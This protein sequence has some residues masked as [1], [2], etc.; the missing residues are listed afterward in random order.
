MEHDAADG[1]GE[2]RVPHAIEHHL[3]NG[4]LAR[5]TLTAGFK[6]NS[7]GQAVQI[8]RRLQG[9]LVL[10]RLGSGANSIDQGP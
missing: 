3:G 10:K 9:A 2:G 5:H 1:A 4:G 8:A 7:R 6:I